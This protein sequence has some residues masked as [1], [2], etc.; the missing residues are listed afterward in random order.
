MTRQVQ[1]AVDAGEGDLEARTLRQRLASN[2]NDLDARILLA[3]LYSRRGLPDL[4]IE[5]YRIAA[6][7]FPD[8]V[9]A[10]LGLAKALRDIGEP[11][12]AVQAVHDSLKNHPGGS[13]ELL[14]LEGI[15]Q[16]EQGRF[17]DAE[18]AHR[19]AVG[20]EP[21]RSALHNNLGYNLL[22]QSR[23]ED[24]AAEFRRAIEL[25]PRSDIAHNNLGTALASREHSSDTGAAL[26]EL[27][28][29]AS[30]AVAHNNL[31]AVLIEQGR[32]AEARIELQAALGFR[33]DFPAALANLKM[34]AERDG[35]PAT[36]PAASEPVNFWKRVASTWAKVSGSKSAPKAPASSSGGAEGASSSVTPRP[37]SEQT[38]D[39]PAAAAGKE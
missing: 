32:Y 1:N 16:D 7:R 35:R 33:A 31:A 10:A 2:A 27:Q 3:R 24:A 22:L 30:P 4:A 12:E 23:M 29:S 6:A 39:G 9:A 11:A 36:V 19:A 5:H 21:G 17:A 20:L 34:V 8:S 25:D 26:S 13:W 37:L 18:T 38:V 15:L 28:R 14:S